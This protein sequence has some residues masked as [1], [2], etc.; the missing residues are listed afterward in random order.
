MGEG[1]PNVEGDAVAR[2]DHPGPEVSGVI[3][4][5]ESRNIRAEVMER[6]VR[7]HFQRMPVYTLESFYETQWR[8]V[9]VR[10]IDAVVAVAD[11]LPVDRGFTR[12]PI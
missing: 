12:M 1:S 2:L 7:M 6:L 9:P 5:E 4:A 3:L 10:N 11:R 8:R